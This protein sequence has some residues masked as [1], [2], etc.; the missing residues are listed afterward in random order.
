[1][2]VHISK[3]AELFHKAIEDVWIAE[4]IWSVSPN[5]AVWHCTQAAEKTMK[6]FLRC[7]G[8][9][10]ELGHE[11]G[12][13]LSAVYPLFQLSEETVKSVNYLNRCGSGLRYKN[14]SNDPSQEDA[15]NAT[16]RTK[17][18]LHEFNENPKISQFIDEAKE[19]RAKILKASKGL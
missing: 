8:E 15:K 2:N 11:L 17:Q 19:V 9:D 14:M 16:A 5:N 12:V 7:F 4:Q 18:I 10:Y 3:K 1:M 13:L 6:G